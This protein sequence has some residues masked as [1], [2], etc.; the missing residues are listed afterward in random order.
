MYPLR[1]PPFARTKN[2]PS[3]ARNPLILSPN[4][5]H[6][7]SFHIHTHS[8]MDALFQ[9]LKAGDPT[10]FQFLPSNCSH[11]P[12]TSQKYKTGKTRKK[13]HPHRR[14]GVDPQSLPDLQDSEC[15]FC[16]AGFT[17]SRQTGSHRAYVK[18]GFRPVVI[19]VHSTDID[20]FITGK[21]KN[22]INHHSQPGFP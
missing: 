13:K 21:Q 14:G 22:R 7:F 4:S 11:Q 15:V 8:K 10:L 2:Y 3:F 20:S 12:R 18:Q 9:S 17:F 1:F 16:L 6:G 5:M 19:P